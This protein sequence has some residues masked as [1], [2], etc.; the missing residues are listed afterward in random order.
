MGRGPVRG[1]SHLCKRCNQRYRRHDSVVSVQLALLV[2]GAVLLIIRRSWVRAPPAPPSLSC[3]DA[4][5]SAPCD[6][7]AGTFSGLDGRRMYAR[8]HGAVSPASRISAAVCSA[9]AHRI[10]APIIRGDSYGTFPSLTTPS[11]SSTPGCPVLWRSRRLVHADAVLLPE[12]AAFVSVHWLASL[13]S[14]EEKGLTA[15]HR[16]VRG[17][18]DAD[19]FPG[20][21]ASALVAGPD[22]SGMPDSGQCRGSLCPGEISEEVEDERVGLVRCFQRDEMRGAGYLDV[23]GVR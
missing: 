16:R 3:D 12:L 23:V 5:L 13:Q 1:P 21:K 19:R 22:R 7:V 9:V 4:L 10:H 8:G 11:S 17:R 15:P 14:A 2:H 6:R 18:Q 20:I